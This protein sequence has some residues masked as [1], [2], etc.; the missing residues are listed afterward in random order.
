VI[1]VVGGSFPILSL[2]FSIDL[3]QMDHRNNVI[4]RIWK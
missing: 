2:N 3:D 1:Q 4:E